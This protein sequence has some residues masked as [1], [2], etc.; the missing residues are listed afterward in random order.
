MPHR[1]WREG[2][3]G[4]QLAGVN[5]GVWRLGILAAA[6][7]FMDRRRYLFFQ[8]TALDIFYIW[9]IMATNVSFQCAAGCVNR[10]KQGKVDYI[11]LT[12]ITTKNPS[13]K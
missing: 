6:D 3:Q 2:W 12:V 8:L 5:D 9:E 10:G 13:R 1:R 7:P 4:H 11:S